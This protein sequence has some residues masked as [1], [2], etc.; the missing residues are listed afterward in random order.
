MKSS[1]EMVNSLYE[2]R[3]QYIAEQKTKRKSTMKI[4]ASV[5]SLC[6]VALTGFVVWRSGALKSAPIQTNDT[7]GTVQST[8]ND[9]A[10]NENTFRNDGNRET[11]QTAGGDTPSAD[12]SG[13]G[14]NYSVGGFMI[15]FPPKSNNITFKGEKIT[16]EEATAYFS[17]NRVS[18]VSAFSASGVPADNIKISEHGYCH[19]SYDGTEGKGLEVIQNFRDFLVYNGNRLAAIITLTKENG[20]ISNT[21]SFGAPWFDNYNEYLKE[22]TGQKL[23]YVYASNMEIIIAPD[24]SYVNPMGY[25]VSEYLNRVKNPYEWFYN[26]NIVFIP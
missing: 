5:F 1:K 23:I 9:Q 3:D 20:V 13:N 4:T 10:T 11:Q 17:E 6:L 26:E 24:E 16:D 25:E 7:P 15:P 19:I 12:G 8:D 18:I 14:Y 22:H 21:S 2:R